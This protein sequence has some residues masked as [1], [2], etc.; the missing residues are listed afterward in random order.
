[1]YF[2]INTLSTYKHVID[3]ARQY[4]KPQLNLKLNLIM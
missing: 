2:Y 4:P 3:N 1:M